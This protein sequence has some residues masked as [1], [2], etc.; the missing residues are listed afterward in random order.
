MELDTLQQTVRNNL[1]SVGVPLVKI[2]PGGPRIALTAAPDTT[3]H[4]ALMGVEGDTYAG[5]P[6]YAIVRATAEPDRYIAPEARWKIDP[7]TSRV[8]QS[9]DGAANDLRMQYA[10]MRS[11]SDWSEWRAFT[12]VPNGNQ[13]W[14][15]EAIQLTGDGVSDLTAEHLTMLAKDLYH[16]RSNERCV[17]CFVSV[18]AAT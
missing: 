12:G 1:Q 10:V 8:V 3:F 17:E 4:V 14:G 9:P 13:I 18:T 16:D 11:S 6:K 5:H 15:V 2:H 7:R